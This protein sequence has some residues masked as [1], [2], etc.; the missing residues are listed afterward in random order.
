MQ[1]NG[2]LIGACMLAL[3][4]CLG[5]L[6]LVDVGHV[7]AG[8]D[9]DTLVYANWLGAADWPK[10]NTEV[11]GYA[12][13]ATTL[14][15]LKGATVTSDETTSRL[16]MRRTDTMGEYC[17]EF[18]YRVELTR[19]LALQTPDSKDLTI[20][21]RV[22]PSLFECHRAIN[23]KYLDAARVPM[24]YVNIAPTVKG[25]GDVCIV[26]DARFVGEDEGKMILDPT[27]NSNDTRS[28]YG[29]F[30][31]VLVHLAVER[32]SSFEVLGL[33]KEM[34]A[35][36]EAQR[37]AASGTPKR[38]EMSLS[39]ASAQVQAQRVPGASVS[40][41]HSATWDNAACQ[42]RFAVTQRV[43][44]LI[45]NESDELVSDPKEPYTYRS[46]E[47]R[48]LDDAKNPTKTDGWGEPTKGHYH[49]VMVAWGDNLLPKVVYQPLEVT[50]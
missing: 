37:V 16:L 5:L 29:I 33:L 7:E 6:A 40:L 27:W 32:D 34:V 44:N 17:A 42:T 41:S 2:R 1:R 12:F 18:G 23:D 14:D 38:P 10:T 28:L 35:Q 22:S 3:A 30:H 26:H 47:A 31:N 49:V 11:I 45:L 4:G 50:D 36:M 20:C 19:S 15:A 21:I 25:L 13:D 48:H 8:E 46:L 9:F 43:A 24:H 39:L